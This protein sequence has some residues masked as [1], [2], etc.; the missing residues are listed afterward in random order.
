MDKIIRAPDGCARRHVAIA[1][2]V[3]PDCWFA[4]RR[5]SLLATEGLLPMQR[6][7]KEMA[8]AVLECW[9]LCHDLLR[10]VKEAK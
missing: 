6:E 3:I 10:A 9:Y 8:E 1:D 2:I 7:Y 5:L 4:Y